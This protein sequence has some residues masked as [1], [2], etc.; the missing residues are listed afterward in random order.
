MKISCNILKKHIK[1][2]ENIDWLKVWDIF[3]IRTAEVEGVEVKGSNLDGVVV[4]EIKSVENHPESKK[5]HIL[6]VDAGD[7]ELQIVCGA[8]NVKV[9]LKSALVKIGGHIDGFEI[10]KRPLV[11]IDS[12]GMMCSKRELG[13]SEEHE[14]I[15][16][17]PD[18]LEVGKE[19]ITK[20]EVEA[21]KLSIKNNNLSED[22]VEDVLRDFDYKKIEDITKNNFAEI[23]RLLKE[24]VE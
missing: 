24:G 6:K 19:K 11:G 7:E 13:I 9:G 4:A 22:F 15:V 16:E 20:N 18:D 12:Y 3:T 2:S 10:S 14:G 8:P 5:L 17:L 21:L 1:N 23:V